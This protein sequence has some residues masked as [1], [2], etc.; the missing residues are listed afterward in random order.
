VE[1][2][3]KIAII[4]ATPREYETRAYSLDSVTVGPS[5]ESR[6]L[7]ATSSLE[8]FEMPFWLGDIRLVLPVVSRSRL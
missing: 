1:V 5:V 6:G 2:R 3:V 8:R 7:G 4:H